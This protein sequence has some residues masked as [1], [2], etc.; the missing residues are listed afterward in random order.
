MSGGGEGFARPLGGNS[1]GVWTEVVARTRS[2][3]YR[4]FGHFAAFFFLFRKQKTKEFAN[5]IVK[6]RLNKEA[7]FFSDMVDAAI[8]LQ[9]P[10][11]LFAK[12]MTSKGQNSETLQ[13][14]LDSTEDVKF[15]DLLDQFIHDANISVPEGINTS[16][17]VSRKRRL[18]ESAGNVTSVIMKAFSNMSETLRESEEYQEIVKNLTLMTEEERSNLT[19]Q[20]RNPEENPNI[21]NIQQLA[22]L[23]N[24]NRVLFDPLLNGLADALIGPFFEQH[25]VFLAYMCTVYR[26]YISNF[27]ILFQFITFV[28]LKPCEICDFFYLQILFNLS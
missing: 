21:Q 27:Q 14:I 26:F 17:I 28:S 7:E 22:G 15:P 11:F 10:D 2:V 6:E 23:Q 8:G 16:K 3:L 25:C 13:E 18:I 4:F 12:T 1:P 20:L 5:S 24:N 9:N 19:L